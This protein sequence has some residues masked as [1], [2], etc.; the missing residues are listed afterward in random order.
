MAMQAWTDSRQTLAALFPG[1]VP[2]GERAGGQAAEQAA[3]ALAPL[4]AHI[5]AGAGPVESVPLV[6]PGWQALLMRE[7]VT[8]SQFD[9]LIRLLREGTPLPGGVACIAGWG[10]GMHGF[11]G[12]PW[13]AL[14]GNLHLVV[15]LAPGCRVDRFDAAYPALAA[16]CA[17]EAADVVLGGGE[18]G[19][20]G[21]RHA[22]TGG[23][24]SPGFAGIKWVNDVVISGSKVG[25]VLAWTQTQQQRVTSVV[26]GIGLNVE[27]TPA[28]ERSPFVPGATSLREVA[29]TGASPALGDAVAPL[30][31]ALARGHDRLLRDGADW[32][33]EEYRARSVVIGRQVVVLREDAAVPTPASPPVGS[34]P[35][36]GET[37]AAGRV[38]GIGNGL[39]LLLEGTSDPVTRGRLLLVEEG[40]PPAP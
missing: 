7:Q 12:R 15:H 33:L 28:V 23:A 38:L 34:L 16:V 22:G 37:I 39:E 18:A 9:T 40:G 13:Q 5:Y 2:D 14:P 35:P 27:T 20:L 19:S 17:A 21:S 6:L 36:G 11:R 26:L 4:R 31:Q 1:R 8:E 10:S 24:G 3:A 29:P 32:L 30:L 25:G